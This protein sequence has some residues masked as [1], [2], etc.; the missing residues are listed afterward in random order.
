MAE[1]STS[2]IIVIVIVV[3]LVVVS[4]GAALTRHLNPVGSAEARFNPPQSQE[5]YM[6]SVRQRTRDRFRRISAHARDVESQCMLP[7]G[8]VNKE[9]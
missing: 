2:A 6:Q 7:P 5:M 9:W 8:W 1:L 3:C 4:I